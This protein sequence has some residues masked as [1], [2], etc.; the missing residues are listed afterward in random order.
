MPEHPPDGTLVRVIAGPVRHGSVSVWKKGTING[1][2]RHCAL[3]WIIGINLEQ[4]ETIKVWLGNVRV[5][6]A[7][8][9]LAEL[10][11]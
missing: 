6:S 4:G 8:D 11:E 9:A 1:T 2:P 5:I 10:A 3:G 7:V